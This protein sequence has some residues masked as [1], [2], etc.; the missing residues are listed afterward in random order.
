M[1]AVSQE[2][3]GSVT[4]DLSFRRLPETGRLAERLF[5]NLEAGQAKWKA[6]RMAQADLR[7]AGYYHPFFWGAFSLIG[8]P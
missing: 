4:A 1:R 3:K 6:L 5:T 2:W 7:K 8:E